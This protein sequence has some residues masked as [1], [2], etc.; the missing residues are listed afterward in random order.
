[1]RFGEDRSKAI[2]GLQRVSRPGLRRYVTSAEIPRLRGGSGLVIVS[3]SRGVM[4]GK[5]A[6]RLRCG[7]ELMA[8]VW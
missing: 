1:L 7:G 2:T 6:K 3:T 5:Q 4:S 8:L